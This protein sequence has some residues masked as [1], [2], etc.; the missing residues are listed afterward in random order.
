MNGIRQLPTLRVS[1]VDRRDE[2]RHA[3]YQIPT[4]AEAFEAM[5]IVE[6]R[7]NRS[8]RHKRDCARNPGL[9]AH[10]AQH[11]AAMRGGS[12]FRLAIIL[13]A[14]V[15]AACSGPTPT[16]APPTATPTATATP[17][18]VP[19]TATP[20]ATAT[21]T[22]VPPTATPTP[23]KT[24]T[25]TPTATPVPTATAT[26]TPTATPRPTPTPTPGFPATYSMLMTALGPF[27]LP[28]QLQGCWRGGGRHQ[29]G[30]ILLYYY[31]ADS[32]RCQACYGPVLYALRKSSGPLM[33]V[34]VMNQYH[35]H[36]ELTRVLTIFGYN[37][38][39]ADSIASSHLRDSYR[40]FTRDDDLKSNW[41]CTTPS[42]INLFSY[43]TASG[44]FVTLLTSR[45]AESWFD[46]SPCIA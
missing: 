38:A 31:G 44:S 42:G 13:L 18:P 10:R 20:T 5:R 8:T 37:E 22:P 43:P 14:L 28:H 1:D 46:A 15:L 25:A 29:D 23:T 26:P 21:P 39:Q 6:A 36:P 4:S 9:H 2:Y 41:S 3:A 17:T 33:E 16:P 24:P 19:P 11:A 32:H 12:M 45:E 30:T 27:C 7:R 34:W 35:T 40:P